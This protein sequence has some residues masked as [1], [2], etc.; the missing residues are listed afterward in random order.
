MINVFK[1]FFEKFFRE[2][3]SIILTL[4]VIAFFTVMMT[5]GAIIAP[6]LWSLILT[7]MLLGLVNSLVRIHVPRPVA[8]YAV[9]LL[10]LGAMVMVVLIFL[11]FTWNRLASLINDLPG[12]LDQLRKLLALLPENYPEVFSAEQVQRWLNVIQNELMAKGQAMLSYSFSSVTKIVTFAVYTVLVPIMVFFMMKDS[13]KLLNWMENWLP[14]KRPVMAQIWHEMNGQLANYIRGKALE[15]IIVGGASFLIFAILGLNYALLLAI[16]VG[17]SVIIPFVGAT[18]VA[19]PVFLVGFFQ[20]G[21]GGDLYQLMIAYVVLQM[22]DGNIL[23]P[24]IFSETVNLHPIAI[25]AAVLVFGGF[26]G[27]WGVFFAIPLATFIKALINAWPVGHSPTPAILS[28]EH[29]K[30]LR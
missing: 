27:F 15:I 4:I 17:F 11:P 30:D 20:W 22:V 25:I 3:E 8:V 26:W 6:L 28:H 5:M 7:Y 14:E 18:I 21:F 1:G 9:Y 23:V 16:M 13:Q 2:E 10:F 12:M 19:L 24:L 29:H